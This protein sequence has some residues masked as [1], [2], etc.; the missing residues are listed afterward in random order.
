MHGG[1]AEDGVGGD[2]EWSSSGSMLGSGSGA[3]SA[4]NDEVVGEE[5]VEVEILSRRVPSGRGR[6]LTERG[7]S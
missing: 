4:D 7:C 6:P 2:V 3:W 5:D 1:S